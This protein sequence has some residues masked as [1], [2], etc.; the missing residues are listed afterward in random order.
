MKNDTGW[1]RISGASCAVV[2]LAGIALFSAVV[3]HSSEEWK[4]EFE[5]VCS[6]TDTLTDMPE[7][8]IA[9]LLERCDKLATSLDAEDKSFRKVNLFRL[10][11]C[12]DLISFMLDSK[13]AA[14]EP[15][16]KK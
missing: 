6:K 4:T 3:C 5:A 14:K 7:A 2:V 10:K 16:E 9:S 1:G 11:T 15:E 8:E 12:R 13:R